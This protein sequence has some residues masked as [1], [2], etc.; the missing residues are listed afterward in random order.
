MNANTWA[1]DVNCAI[2]VCDATGIIIYMNDRAKELYASRGNLIGRNLFDCHPEAAANKIREM[3]ASGESNSYTI[4]KNERR[5]VIYQTPWR[6]PD[7]TVG[8]M[9]E[10]SMIVPDQMPHYNRDSNND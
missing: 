5:K 4:T 1:D 6:R 3:L 10:I 7:G 2:T 9:V 8:G